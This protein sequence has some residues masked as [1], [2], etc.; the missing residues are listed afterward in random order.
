MKLIS[1]SQSSI[2]VQI[3]KVIAD[4]DVKLVN[5]SREIY[6]KFNVDSES[7]DITFE[8]DICDINI[9]QALHLI[10]EG[11]DIN[12]DILFE[13][14][15][16]DAS[17]LNDEFYVTRKIINAATRGL[18]N[19]ELFLAAFSALAIMPLNNHFYGALITLS[20][21]KYLEAPEGREWVLDVLNRC[22]IEFDDAPTAKT[23]N[24]VRWG[25]SS[26]TALS[27]ALLLNDKVDEAD[28]ILNVVLSHYEPNYNQL[29]LWNYCQC[30]ILK[31]AI[32]FYK[33]KKAEAGWRFLSAFDFSRKS[34]N[35]IYNSRND[36]VLGQISDCQALLSLGELALK[37]GVKCLGKIPSESRYA[38]ISFNGKVNFTPVFARFHSSRAKFKSAFFE[39]VEKEFNNS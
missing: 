33:G 17:K 38:D 7:G 20:A 15:R 8:I 35:D 30:L 2:K 3:S 32:L 27:L 6:P 39:G 29:S 13:K 11:G 9:Y 37:C 22:K 23:P 26:A 24:I 34:I 1:I 18:D 5:G 31:S 10:V 19:N 16:L 28:R 12:L 25:I 21:Y 14:Y 36:W 4:G